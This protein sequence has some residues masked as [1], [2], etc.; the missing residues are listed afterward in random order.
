MKQ[1]AWSGIRGSSSALL[2]GALLSGL[3]GC[4]GDDALESERPTPPD[5]TAGVQAVA[6]AELLEEHW[7]LELTARPFAATSYGVRRFDDRLPPVRR[8]EV[9][10]L[11]EQRRALLA[12]AEALSPALFNASDLAS[13]AVLVERLAAAIGL[14]ACEYERWDVSPR[15]SLADQLETLGNTHLLLDEQDAA[16]Y[17]AR[18]DAMS[19]A[20]DAFGEELMAG[21]AGGLVATRPTLMA[22]RDRLRGWAI[23][24]I[25]EWPL[26]LAIAGS[27]LGPRQAQQLHDEVSAR[28][29]TQLAP[30]YRRLADT[31]E[32]RLLPAAR[33]VEGLVGLA[34][35]AACYTAE[36]RRHTTLPMSAAELHQLGLSEVARI[37]GATIALGRQLFGVETLAAIRDRL[38]AAP[39]QRFR[40]EEELLTWVQGIITRAETQMKPLFAHLPTTKLVLQPY[41]ASAGQVAASY[42]AS[43]GGSWPATYYL[44]TQPP[45]NQL[46]ANLESTT[47]HEAIPGHHLQLGRPLAALPAIRSELQDTAYVEGWALYAET[48]ADEVGLYT[49]DAARLGRLANEALRAVRLVVDTGLH[50]EGWTRQQALDY[51]NQHLL[52]AGDFAVSEVARYLQSPGQALAY[53]V[54][55]LELLRLRAELRAE[56]GG[57]FSLREFHEAVL[58]GGSLPLPVLAGQLLGAAGEAARTPAGS[59]LAAQ[60]GGWRTDARPPR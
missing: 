26:L 44:V 42:Q 59:A 50:A 17:L 18:V 29:S 16:S 7:E 10:A 4:N 28:I 55:E 1:L 13:R 6:L 27:L 20:L 43:P 14:D 3:G 22:A 12:R 35:G 40:S 23:R 38:A 2:L 30:A 19:A 46:R 36:I 8:S 15:R 58:T 31:I 25:S 39:G 47:Y 11:R 32:T 5:P 41:P 45:Q 52:F 9:L 34:G 33:D 53:K 51:M 21:A 24:P 56:R 57:A 48:L 60:G 37:D 54:G 49:D